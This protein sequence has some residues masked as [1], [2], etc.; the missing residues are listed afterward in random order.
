M[1][2]SGLVKRKY[3]GLELDPFQV[4]AFAA[5]DDDR[6]LVVAAP[7]GAGKTIIAEYAIEQAL[8]TGRR[9]IY[10][11]PI[12]ALSNQKYRD[13]AALYGNKIG[14][15]TGDVSLTPE[16]PVL[17]MT[18][19]I[20]RNAILESPERYADVQYC[21]FD[22]V[23]YISDF[24]RGTVWEES[25]IF[26]PPQIRILALSATIPNIGQIAEWIEGLRGHP[27]TI[28]QEGQRPVPLHYLFHAH[29][30]GIFAVKSL[31][32]Y[33]PRSRK[34]QIKLSRRGAEALLD[35]C[36][37]E[38]RMPC[39]YFAFN[40]R[41]CEVKAWRCR[42]RRLVNEAEADILSE[43]IAQLAERYGVAAS[44]E[45]SRL[46]VLWRRGIAFHHAGML[47]MYKEIVERLFTEGLIKLLF[48]TETFALGVNMPACSVIFDSMEKFDG[49]E[50]RP[51]RALEFQQ[52]AGRAGRR[53]MDPCGYVYINLMSFE[54]LHYRG[55]REI[56]S[57]RVE[58]VTS[59]LNLSYST[60]MN[61]IERL[62]DEI[63]EAEDKSLGRFLTQ[64]NRPEI[65]E[66]LARRRRKLLERKI[67][68]LV[69][70]GYLDDAQKLT[71]RG[72]YAAQINGYEMQ[73]TELFFSGV[74]E[75]L[76]CEQLA[77]VLGALIYE[78]KK[79]VW[80]SDVHVG[81]VQ[82]LAKQV[83][84]RIRQLRKVES[85]VGVNE[86][87]K[88]PDFQ[89]GSVMC[90]WCRGAS[91]EEINQLTS[92][93]DGDVI[94]TIR[95]SIQLIRQLRQASKGHPALTDALQEAVERM[96]RDEADA[97]AQLRVE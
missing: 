91:L 38:G 78:G 55:L 50:F 79:K 37:R 73:L 48:A 7:T 70:L 59:Q 19:E 86:L 67:A 26:A 43:A 23:H 21:I 1:T 63:Y 10:T 35:H 83:Q 44:L 6:S 74:L 92:L 84:R 24:D 97:E 29:K 64:R 85:R 96:K 93:S 42:T 56:I 36:E 54:N 18:T 2:P 45:G 20:F 33:F 9:V 71:P 4:K 41:E 51:L 81:Q 3:R 8:E 89:I 14:I 47:P 80:F 88:Q 76:D 82:P 95:L 61:L 13:F 27:V 12:K 53:G 28:V 94:R 60:I 66:K 87:S 65:A 52:M 49:V 58:P 90:A 30:R 34:F 31:K 57:G 32:K 11:S 16:A 25:L 72:V 22:E 62:G 68:L 77:I 40:R 39:L 69:E 46:L 5:I 17:I 75:D 15:V